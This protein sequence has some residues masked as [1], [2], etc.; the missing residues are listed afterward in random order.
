MS[1]INSPD[2][3]QEKNYNTFKDKFLA[4]FETKYS[5]GARQRQFSDCRMILEELA[6]SLWRQGGDRDTKFLF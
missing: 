3:N 6:I 2:L 1:I 5:L 4:Y